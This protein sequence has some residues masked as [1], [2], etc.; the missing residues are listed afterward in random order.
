MC[1]YR[2]RA[3]ASSPAQIQRGY[4]YPWRGERQRCDHG[5]LAVA[6]SSVNAPP[7]SAARGRPTMCTSS[8]A[9]SNARA[10]NRYGSS[11]LPAITTV[12]APVRPTRTRNSLTS[13]LRLARRVAAVEDVARVEDEVDRLP[14]DEAREVIEDRLH[15]VQPLE[16]LPAA[17]DVPVAGVHDPHRGDPTRAGTGLRPRRR[18]SLRSAALP[19][20]GTGSSAVSGSGVPAG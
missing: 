14:L 9:A 12:R 11:W 18:P 20:R 4:P 8:P 13:P 7:R 10:S 17:S 6:G 19:R 2:F 15:L 3:D 16:A 1:A 5:L